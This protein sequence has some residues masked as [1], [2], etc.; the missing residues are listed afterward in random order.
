[1]AYI[2]EYMAISMPRHVKVY[3]W[4]LDPSDKV[5]TIIEK[6][7]T[8]FLKGGKVDCPEEYLRKRVYR[9]ICDE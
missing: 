1:M 3:N 9:L 6:R 2:L 7:V 4:N 5:I 8:K